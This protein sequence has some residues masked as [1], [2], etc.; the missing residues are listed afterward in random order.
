MKSKPDAGSTPSS[1]HPHWSSAVG[2]LG[3]ILTLLVFGG[4]TEARQQVEG[5]VFPGVLP[6]Y[7]DPVEAPAQ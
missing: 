1:R 6:E 4:V 3:R 5:F 7:P 2:D